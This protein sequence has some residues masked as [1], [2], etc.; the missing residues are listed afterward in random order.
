LASTAFQ[1][2]TLAS[3][4]VIC[5]V[6]VHTGCQVSVTVRPAPVNAG[7]VFVRTD[8]EVGDNRIPARGEAVVRTRLGTVIGN[9]AGTTVSTTEHLMAAMAALG[10]D[11]AVVELDGPELPIMDGSA[12]P[13][14]ELLDGAGLRAQEAPRRYIEILEPVEVVDGDRLARLSPSDR[15]E[16]AFEI[17]FDS[18]AIGRQSIDLTLDE[19]SFR[20]N[21]ADSRTFGFAH[22]VE[23]LRQAGLA[24]GGSLDNVIVI[25]GDQV[26]NPE[27]LRR[28]DELVRHKAIDALGDL[29]LMGPIIGRF[30]GVCAG[31]GLNNALVRALL[32][33]PEAWRVRILSETFAEAV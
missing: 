24:L 14:V 20:T 31:H 18:D 8:I 33:R 9:A 1:Q 23:A 21:L 29:Y 13:F 3:A 15:F 17:I 26:M 11:N 22:E 6:G 10:V 4:A 19:A 27:G 16:I 5:G 2:H 7:I 28:P 25:D 30:E 12:L 32:A